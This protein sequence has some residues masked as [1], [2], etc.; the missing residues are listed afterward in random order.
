MTLKIANEFMPRAYI[1]I[2]LGIKL[3]D[4]LIFRPHGDSLA[5]KNYGLLKVPLKTNLYDA[6]RP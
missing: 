5:K 6:L 2:F 3:D 1:E 4:K